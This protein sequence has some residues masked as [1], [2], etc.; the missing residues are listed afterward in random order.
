MASA[1]YSLPQFF[2]LRWY[3]EC[4]STEWNW[5]SLL[6]L[7]WPLRSVAAAWI[8]QIIAD[9]NSALAQLEQELRTRKSNAAPV[10]ELPAL[11]VSTGT[12][13]D[14]YDPPST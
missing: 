6:G 14:V 13:P 4:L 12:G 3:S 1:S 10:I 9:S 5:R 7:C 2:L 11:E 8:C